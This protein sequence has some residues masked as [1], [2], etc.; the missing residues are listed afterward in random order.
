M[1]PVLSQA[2][3]SVLQLSFPDVLNKNGGIATK[4]TLTNGGKKTLI[5]AT[6]C[7]NFARK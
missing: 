2:A 3:M 4:L 5:S 6:V 7:S 1:H